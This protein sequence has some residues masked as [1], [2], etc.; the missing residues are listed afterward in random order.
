MHASVI[1]H[2]Y[3]TGIRGFVGALAVASWLATAGSAAANA[4]MLK[5]GDDFPAWQLVDQNGAAMASAQ[6]AGKRYLV[7]F[8]PKAMTSGCT[9]EGQGLRDHDADLKR[10]DV[11]VLGVSFDEPSAN[12]EFRTTQNFPFQLLSD[13]DRKLAMAVGAADSPQQPTARRISYLVGGNGKVL[14]A[15]DS[16]DPA[17]HAAQVLKDLSALPRE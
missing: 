8:Y 7:W 9:A 1:Q 4:A 17:S 16:V 2:G 5:A 10:A 14:K 12:A 3:A 6:L 15:Y 13:R 11:I